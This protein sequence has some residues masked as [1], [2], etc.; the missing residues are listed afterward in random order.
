L[1][2]SDRTVSLDMS[3]AYGKLDAQHR[4]EAVL[5]RVHWGIISR[6]VSATAQGQ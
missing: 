1:F 5:D 2:V 3:S 6:D 4:T